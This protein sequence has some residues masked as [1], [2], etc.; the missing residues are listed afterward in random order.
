MCQKKYLIEEVKDKSGKDIDL[1][2]WT[3]EI[4]EDLPE[5]EN[6]CV[7][8]YLFSIILFQGAIINWCIFFFELITK[9]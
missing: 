8:V 5:Q 7:F 6:G 1:S 3:Q 9:S 2:S 4:V